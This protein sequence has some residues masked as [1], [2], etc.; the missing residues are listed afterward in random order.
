MNGTDH[1][2]VEGGAT[3]PQELAAFSAESP[4][5]STADPVLQRALDMF[6]VEEVG[7]PDLDDQVPTKKKKSSGGGGGDLT[8]G[9][10]SPYGSSN[11]YVMTDDDLQ[12]AVGEWCS[13]EA[14][15]EAKYGHISTWNTGQV[16]NMFHLFA[17]SGKSGHC[18][19]GDSNTFN[20]DISNW[21]GKCGSRAPP[22]CVFMSHHQLTCAV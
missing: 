6:E 7:N 9:L 1:A 2:V 8:R 10:T 20:A 17:P 19:S 4:P 21:D 11:P 16:T 18:G 15:A 13:D 12:D 14:A 22:F 3:V 5:R